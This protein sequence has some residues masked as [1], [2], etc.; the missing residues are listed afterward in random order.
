MRFATTLCLPI[1]ALMLAGCASSKTP[2]TQP[3][4]VPPL[5]S[6]LAAD[7]DT[8]TAP[9]ALDYDVW[10]D[11]MTGTVLP[12]YKTCALRHHDTVAAWPGPQVSPKP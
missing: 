7:C 10:Q 5:R 6:D 9:T 12:A 8:L 2:L 1:V 11:W 3:A 4:S